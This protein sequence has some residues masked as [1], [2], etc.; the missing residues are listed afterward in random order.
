MAKSK[1]KAG[2]H[3]SEKSEADWMAEND[4]RTLIDAAEIRSNPD[5]LKRAMVK[6]REMQKNLSKVRA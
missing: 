1:V 4:L 2:I 3:P 6:K 5:R